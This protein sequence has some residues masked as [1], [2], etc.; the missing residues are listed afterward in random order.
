MPRR[1]LA[2]GASLQAGNLETDVE[3][4][5]RPRQWV[6][7]F[8]LQNRR[9]CCCFIPALTSRTGGAGRSGRRTSNEGVKST[10]TNPFSRTHRSLTFATRNDART[11]CGTKPISPKGPAINRLPGA[12]LACRQMPFPSREHQRA[13]AGSQE[14]VRFAFLEFP[15]QIFAGKTMKIIRKKIIRKEANFD[16]PPEMNK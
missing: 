13:L 2:D 5:P 9:K 10:K 6:C 4:V 8:E 11:I 12:F 16:K 1:S 3:C 15:A 7:S 14:W